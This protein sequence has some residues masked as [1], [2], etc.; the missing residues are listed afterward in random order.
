MREIRNFEDLL[1]SKYGEPGSP[2]RLDFEYKAQAYYLCELLKE[3]RRK[4]KM[5]QEDLA[6][7]TN[8]KK[9]FLSRVENGKVDIQLST[10]LKIIKGLGVT[11]MLDSSK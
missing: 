7:R 8:L 9:T 6:R 4:A 11:F 2:D 5:T 3:E 1:K 10:F